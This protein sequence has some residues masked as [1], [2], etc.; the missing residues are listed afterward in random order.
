MDRAVPAM[1]SLDRTLASR[2]ECKYFVAPEVLPALRAMARP[3]V[4]PDE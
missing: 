1:P 4:R 3:F 2:H